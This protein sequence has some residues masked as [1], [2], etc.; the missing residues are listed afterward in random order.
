MKILR[1]TVMCI[2]ALTGTFAWGH[3]FPLTLN[4]N[5]QGSPVSISVG[6]QQPVLDQ[7]GTAPPVGSPMNSNLFTDQF[8]NTGTDVRGNFQITDEGGPNFDYINGNQ[9]AWL[10]AN[11]TITFSLTSPLY[12]SDGTNG[13]VAVPA[14]G[15]TDVYFSDAA[16]P[17]PNGSTLHTELSGGSLTP[18]AGFQ[19]VSPLTFGDGSVPGEE[20][21]HEMIKQLYIDPTSKQTSGEYGFAFEITCISQ[22]A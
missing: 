7:D 20:A 3:G 5:G 17:N 8:L 15:S 12:Y 6:S 19:M 18:V 22:A 4:V 11:P 13:G 2:V 1:L 14:S 16:D 9:A 21:G 10:A